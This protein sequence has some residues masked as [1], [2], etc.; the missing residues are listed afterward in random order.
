[1]DA[2]LRTKGNLHEGL[3]FV[4][5]CLVSCAETRD[6]ALQDKLLP[7]L[8]T[9]LESREGCSNRVL[10]VLSALGS[11][12]KG[13]EAIKEARIKDTLESMLTNISK[14]HSLLKPLAQVLAQLKDS[15]SYAPGDVLPP[16]ASGQAE[17]P[18]T[19]KV[20]LRGPAVA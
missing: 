20:R 10:W 11:S 7:V 1:M 12:P 3:L 9:L 13:R 19:S 16:I 5:A 18:S 4:A 14:E 2:I 8:E 6:Q 15:E 17:Q